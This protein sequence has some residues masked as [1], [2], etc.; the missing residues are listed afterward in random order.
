[1]I[2]P[3]IYINFILIDIQSKIILY[4]KLYLI[5]IKKMQKFFMSDRNEGQIKGQIQKKKDFFLYS[6]FYRRFF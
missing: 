4:P 6:K 3:N 2:P 5:T 1:M